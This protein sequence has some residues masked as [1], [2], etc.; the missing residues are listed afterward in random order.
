MDIPFPLILPLK[1]IQTFDIGK[2]M[3]HKHRFFVEF[4]RGIFAYNLFC[5]FTFLSHFFYL[6]AANL[7]LR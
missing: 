5:V 2:N 6:A 1:V 7:F 3:E 4:N